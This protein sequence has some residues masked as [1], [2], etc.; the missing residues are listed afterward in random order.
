MECSVKNICFLLILVISVH[1]LYGSANDCIYS[2]SL[3]RI[4]KTSLKQSLLKNPPFKGMERQCFVELL[5]RLSEDSNKQNLEDSF[6][7]FLREYCK[8]CNSF[9]LAL[10]HT[11]NSSLD[12]EYNHNLSVNILKLWEKYNGRVNE[13]LT[14]L[15]QRGLFSKANSLYNEFYILSL[16]DGYDLLK[17]AQIKAILNDYSG[18]AKLFCAV[19]DYGKHFNSIARSQFV[20]MLADADSPHIQRQALYIYKSCFLSKSDIDK[21]SLSLWLSKTYSRFALYQEEIDAVLELDTT[22][23][24]KGSRLLDIAGKRFRKYL[25]SNAIPPAINSWDFLDKEKSRQECVLILYQSYIQIGENDSAL[26][27]LE[28]TNLNDNKS[29][30]NAA[31]LYQATGLFNKADSIIAQMGESVIKDT[32]NIRQYLFNGKINEACSLISKYTYLPRWSSAFAD[33]LLWKVRCA[34]F[35]GNIFKTTQYLDSINIVENSLPKKY[36]REILECKLASQRM[37]TYPDAFSYWGKLYYNIYVNKSQDITHS[38]NVDQWPE[39]IRKHL[40]ITLLNDLIEKEHF[41]SAQYVLDLNPKLHEE[42]QICYFYAE[43]NFKLGYVEKAKKLFENIVL[44]NPD[45]VFAHKARIYLLKLKQSQ[46]M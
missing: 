38:F 42:P 32:L 17:W 43:V 11:I 46:S 40:V 39:D 21:L 29:M 2:D 45:N 10:L 41:Y 6:I 13:Y 20:R 8:A 19:R 14:K 37:E 24:S 44:S 28:K 7:L 35:S 1:S 25:F 33:G 34:V 23:E 9:S 5:K 18:M 15:E 3:W 16:L 36:T 4:Q 12:L 22:A 30:T 31:V 26:I 27:W